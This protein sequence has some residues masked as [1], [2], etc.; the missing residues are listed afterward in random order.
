MP[1]DICQM[2]KVN[3]ECLCREHL[4]A[5]LHTFN[6]NNIRTK[7][8]RKT[9]ISLQMTSQ[10]KLIKCIRK[11]STG[12]RVNGHTKMEKDFYQD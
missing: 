2:T 12:E 8:E 1:S 10:Q 6:N 5:G 4:E 11:H 9:T 7:C 3:A